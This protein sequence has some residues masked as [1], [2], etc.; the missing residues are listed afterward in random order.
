MLTPILATSDPYSAADEFVANGWTLAYATPRESRDPLA[1]VELHGGQVMLGVD[2]EQFLPVAARDLRGAGV[3]FYVEVPAE[4][5]EKVHA[6][7]REA[8][9]IEQRPWGV[10]SFVVRLAAYNFMIATAQ[11]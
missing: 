5:I 9:P 6:A 3:Q 10:R 2:S 4:A 11:G 7:H 1:V 8:G